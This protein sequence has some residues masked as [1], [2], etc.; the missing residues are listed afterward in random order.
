S[1]FNQNHPW[2]AKPPTASPQY[3]KC[4]KEKTQIPDRTDRGL[5]HDIGIY[6]GLYNNVG[7]GTLLTMD[8]QHYAIIQYKCSL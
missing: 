2:G 3:S 1:Q 7:V 5:V 6:W 8:L 4:K